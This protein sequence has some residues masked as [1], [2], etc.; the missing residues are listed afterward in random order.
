M[1]QGDSQPERDATETPRVATTSETR[2]IPKTIDNDRQSQVDHVGNTDSE[3]G[4]TG[5]RSGGPPS[6][7]THGTTGGASGGDITQDTTT[8]YDTP[9]A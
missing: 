8:T 1:L 9:I 2:T 5:V 3:I 4:A 6:G 7:T